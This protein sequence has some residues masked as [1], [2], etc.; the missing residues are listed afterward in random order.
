MAD[1]TI[2]RYVNQFV[3]KEVYWVLKDQRGFSQQQIRDSIEDITELCIVLPT[4]SKEEFKRI[5]VRDKSDRPIVC[6]AMKN[7]LVLYID[8]EKTY[9]DAE[10]Y[11]Q[12]K[13]ISKNGQ[14]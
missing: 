6:S 9:R 12:V 11:V 14:I 8:D 1:N 2:T 13:R 4:P 7:S 3:L 5:A 10:K